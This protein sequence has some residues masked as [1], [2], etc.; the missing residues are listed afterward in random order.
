MTTHKLNRPCAVVLRGVTST[1]AIRLQELFLQDG[2]CLV[3][4]ITYINTRGWHYWG[5][6]SDNNTQVYDY[7]SSFTKNHCGEDEDV[8]IYTYDEVVSLISCNDNTAISDVQATKV[9]LERDNASESNT[10][11]FKVVCNKTYTITIK[12]QEFVLTEAEYV[13]LEEAMR[14]VDE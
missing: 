5:I 11:S 6:D 10:D 14:L 7:L 9:R 8:T 2:A 4:E 3:D 12:G 13:E 1:Q